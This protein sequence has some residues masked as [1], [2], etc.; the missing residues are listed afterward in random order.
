LAQCNNEIISVIDLYNIV[1]S[2]IKV[3]TNHGHCLLTKVD[4]SL[5]A[6]AKLGVGLDVRLQPGGEQLLLF[7]GLVAEPCIT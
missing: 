7:E 4:H 5:V 2:R 3:N 6:V 1:I